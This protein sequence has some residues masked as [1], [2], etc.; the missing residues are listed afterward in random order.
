MELVSAEL[1]VSVNPLFLPS[2]YKQVYPSDNRNYTPN[3]HCLRASKLT[4]DARTRFDL[5]VPASFLNSEKVETEEQER[6]I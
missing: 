4:P 5:Y 6:Y 1:V 3:S 2:G